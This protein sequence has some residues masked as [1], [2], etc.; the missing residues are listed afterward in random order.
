[1]SCTVV[2]SQ[3]MCL[4]SRAIMQVSSQ[5]TFI[6]IPRNR[7]EDIKD[8]FHW[9]F[10]LKDLPNQ[11]I[12]ALKHFQINIPV[13]SHLKSRL[14]QTKCDGLHLSLHLTFPTLQKSIFAFM[15]K[16]VIAISSSW[17]GEIKSRIGTVKNS[18]ER[19][20]RNNFKSSINL[21]VCWKL[22][23]FPY[24]TVFLSGK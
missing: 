16:L 3:K 22:K 19:T 5:A 12:S 14:N 23:A 13:F 6:Q 15:C 1:M 2:V 4:L 9:A 24:R 8:W 18:S 17:L 7:H 11:L 10:V 20:W 21:T